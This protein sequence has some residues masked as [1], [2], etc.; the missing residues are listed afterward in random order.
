[1]SA[2]SGYVM[3]WQG[4]TLFLFDW[5]SATSSKVYT[6]GEDEFLVGQGMAAA[7][8]RLSLAMRIISLF[9]VASNA[10]PNTP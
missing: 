9:C 1:M 5:N 3:F 8:A 10:T 6:L 7:S 2:E 4:R